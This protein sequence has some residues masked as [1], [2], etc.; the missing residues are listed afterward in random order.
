MLP[1][2]IPDG[3]FWDEAR[4]RFVIVKGQT[5][6]VEHSLI[7]VSKWEA[8]WKKAF[9]SQ[10]PRTGDELV[11][12]IR[13]MTVTHVSDPNLYLCITGSH[14]AEVQAYIDDPMS[15]LRFRGETNKKPQG[16]TK[17][18]TS[19]QIYAAMVL[20]G[21]PFEC[22]KWHLNRLLTLIH[23]CEL[24]NNGGKMSRKDSAKMMSQMNAVRRAK[25]H[26][27]G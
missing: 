11:D 10:A 22:E 27:R 21:I 7:S 26:T 25:Y 3:D 9:L 23:E 16:Y 14:I 15:A 5:I 18:K 20:L 4:Q 12:Y 6:Q 2:I 17:P 1:L 19:E 24:L 13:C 8:K